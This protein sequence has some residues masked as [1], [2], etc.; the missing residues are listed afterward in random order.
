MLQVHLPLFINGAPHG[1]VPAYNWSVLRYAGPLRLALAKGMCF[2]VHRGSRIADCQ[3]TTSNTTRIIKNFC[4][5][6]HSFGPMI[7]NGAMACKLCDCNVFLPFH[8]QKL[9]VGITSDH[10]LGIARSP[11]V[12]SRRSCDDSVLRCALDSAK[13]WP[14]RE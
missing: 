12:D 3:H 2:L 13:Q 7:A 5:K 10:S 4:R 11:I 9:S 6:T 14:T 8:S 1:S